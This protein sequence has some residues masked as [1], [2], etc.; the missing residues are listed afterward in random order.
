MA[1]GGDVEGNHAIH[2]GAEEEAL[3]GG[4]SHFGKNG[5]SIVQAGLGGGMG[6]GELAKEVAKKVGK[7]RC[8]MIMNPSVV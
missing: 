5:F 4:T 1:A 6:I 7:P 8:K 2:F 3:G